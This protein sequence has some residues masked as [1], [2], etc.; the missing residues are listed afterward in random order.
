MR[1]ENTKMSRECLVEVKYFQPEMQLHLGKF[2]LDGYYDYPSR[3]VYTNCWQRI[4]DSGLIQ[5]CEVGGQAWWDFPDGVCENFLAYYRAE[6]IGEID[7][8]RYLEKNRYELAQP[9][10]WEYVE[11]ICNGG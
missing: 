3:Y 2:T 11:K 9:I 6:I 8:D 5:C 4:T 7:G 1:D 10:T